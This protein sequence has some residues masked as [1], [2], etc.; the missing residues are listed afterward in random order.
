ML[1]ITGPYTT[2]PDRFLGGPY[3]QLEAIVNLFDPTKGF[4]R[5]AVIGFQTEDAFLD[6]VLSNAEQYVERTW[7][8]I[9]VL[10]QQ[11]TLDT[12]LTDRGDGLDLVPSIGYYLLSRLF[13]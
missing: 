10:F 11:E 4:M 9:P 2:N 12:D 13:G 8:S 7:P 3:L 1:M 6:H 5:V